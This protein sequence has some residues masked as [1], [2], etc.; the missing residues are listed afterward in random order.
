MYTCESIFV[1]CGRKPVDSRAAWRTTFFRIQCAEHSKNPKKLLQHINKV[2]GR[3]K[4]HHLPQCKLAEMTSYFA[5]IVEDP[6]RSDDLSKDRQKTANS[7]DTGNRALCLDEFSPVTSETVVKHLRSIDTSKASGSDGIS[8]LL[9][10]RRG[11]VLAPSLTKIFNTFI[12][13]GTVPHLFKKAT[14]TPIPAHVQIW[15]QESN[16]ELLL[17]IVSK[18]LEK[19]V[20]TQFNPLPSRGGGGGGGGGLSQLAPSC[21]S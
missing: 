4:H 19:V 18:I 7:S 12:V 15:R 9:L 1:I 2:T 3:L 17:P 6:N 5:S 16:R 8:G 11:T 21:S 10:K 20:F 14:I 13:T